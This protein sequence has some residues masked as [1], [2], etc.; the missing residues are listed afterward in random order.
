ML[1]CSAKQ[2]AYQEK[3]ASSTKNFSML[4]ESPDLDDKVK[5]AAAILWDTWKCRSRQVQNAWLYD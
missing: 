1:W 4:K 2:L 3:R 5:S